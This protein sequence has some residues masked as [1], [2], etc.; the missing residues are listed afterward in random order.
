MN[1]S[2]RK[3]LACKREIKTESDSIRCLTQALK[4]YPDD[5]DLLYHAGVLL[6]QAC[7][8][9]EALDAFIAS[10]DH[11]LQE[12]SKKREI[13]DLILTAYYEPNKQ[14]FKKRYEKNV[15][16]FL[17]YERSYIPFFPAF[18]DLRY[19]CVPRSEHEFYIYDRQGQEFLG[20]I[21]NS[22][23]KS[24]CADVEVFNCVL[25]VNIFDVEEL[26]VLH[27]RTV[28]RRDINNILY[29]SKVPKYLIWDYEK[30]QICLQLM[31][32]EPVL[33]TRSFLFWVDCGKESD[34][35]SLVD[36]LKDD[37]ALLPH[38]V[39]GEVSE[40][41]R[42]LLEEVINFRYKSFASARSQVEEMVSCYTK[43]YYR[44]LFRD[45]AKLRILFVM[46]RYTPTLNHSVRADDNCV[47][48]CLDACRELGVA[49][50]LYTYKSEVQWFHYPGA[51]LNK[52][53]EFEPHII[54]DINHHK[55]EWGVIPD[56]IMQVVWVLD[57]AEAVPHIYSPDCVAKVRWNDFFL[58]MTGTF[59]DDLLKI[60]FPKSQILHQPVP[61]NTS[62]FRRRNLNE[63]ERVSYGTDIVYVSN[64]GELDTTLQNQLI[65]L[66]AQFYG[67]YTVEKVGDFLHKAFEVIYKKVAESEQII[68]V[69]GY[70]SIVEKAAASCGI[71]VEPAMVEDLGYRLGFR[72]DNLLRRTV[73]LVWLA[74]AG[75]SLK[76]WGSGW[77]YNSKLK[78][79]A[80]GPV[81]HSELP[82]VLSASK[83]ALGL[84]PRVTMHP[85]ALETMACGCLYICRNLSHDW[86]DI[87][88]YFVEDEDFLCFYDKEDL[89]RKI[90]FFLRNDAVRQRIAENARRKVQENHTYKKAFQSWLSFIKSAIEQ[91][92]I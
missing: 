52:I 28:D 5:K 65:Y 63:I 11:K 47:Y 31:D 59:R 86:E 73:P 49:Y 2:I 38:L 71:K 19:L 15:G 29:D 83:I 41:I 90:D 88:N 58:A 70:R 77:E 37:Q 8:Y 84:N 39:I 23:E 22:R 76:I 62:L 64:V 61:V 66:V 40:K 82:R 4:D 13:R 80:M 85:R 7:R 12:P 75:Y 60:G 51:L 50:D 68:G 48:D 30:M 16:D 27:K 67:R 89:L 69:E 9:E 45:P 42:A 72:L 24:S 91:T 81:S 33:A 14:G 54:F 46:R 35:A 56:N 36:F 78:K 44:E 74:E 87:R 1:E 21:D 18:D 32:Y 20:K 3:A 55:W 25:A 92:D 10:H 17:A 43:E 26:L 79:Y 53:I 34:L 57:P 6:F